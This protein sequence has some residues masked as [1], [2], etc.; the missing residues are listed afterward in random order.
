MCHQQIES[1]MISQASLDSYVAR[2]CCEK[3]KWLDQGSR[4][5]RSGRE[6]V[7]QQ[8]LSQQRTVDWA[9]KNC[10]LCSSAPDV[11][12]ECQQ[13]ILRN[14]QANQRLQQTWNTHSAVVWKP[15]SVWWIQRLFSFPLSVHKSPQLAPSPNPA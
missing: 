8:G 6:S 5:I 15:V 13:K 14:E 11:S 2:A 3:V 7:K 10:I 4:H 9:K 1:G 12:S